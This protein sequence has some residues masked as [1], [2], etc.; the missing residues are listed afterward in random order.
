MSADKGIK[1]TNIYQY[2]KGPQNRLF[3][4][5]KDINIKPFISLFLD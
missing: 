5:S 4:Y 3:N 1:R 2:E